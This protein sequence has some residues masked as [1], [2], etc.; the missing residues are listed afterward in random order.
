MLPDIHTPQWVA[1]E[2]IADS[3]DLNSVARVYASDYRACLF[4]ATQVRYRNIVKEWRVTI[5]C[6]PDSNHEIGI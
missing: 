6:R 4:N 2:Y 1:Y 3:T 5:T